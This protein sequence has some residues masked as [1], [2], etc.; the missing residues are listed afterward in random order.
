[1]N[2]SIRVTLL[3]VVLSV[4]IVASGQT[5]SELRAKYG[6]PQTV[7]LEN[8]RVAVERFLVTP[9]IQMTIRYTN[10]GEPCEAIIKPVPNSIP[11]T[12]LDAYDED[13]MVTAE[14]LKVIDEILSPEKRGKKLSEGQFNGGDPHMKLHHLGC[15]GMYFV[16]FEH[17]MVDAGSSCRGGTYSVT[18]HWS[19]TSCPGETIRPKTNNAPPN[20]SLDAGRGSVF[21]MKL[22]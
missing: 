4:S 6:A 19:K 15:T 22:L 16:T 8:N 2:Y 5:S 7:E 21:R 3:F 10:E 18:I 14:A 12:G 17:A 1:M 9:S 13:R 20:K 11:K